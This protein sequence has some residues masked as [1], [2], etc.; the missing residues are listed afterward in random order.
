MYAAVSSSMLLYATALFNNPIGG[1]EDSG[2]KCRAFS[3]QVC[4]NP[5]AATEQR[6]PTGAAGKSAQAI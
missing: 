3:S 4:R 5:G 2:G 1:T 6:A